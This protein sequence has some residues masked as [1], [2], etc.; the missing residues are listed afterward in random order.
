MLAAK[1]REL[2]DLKKKLDY[3]RSFYADTPEDVEEVS[4]S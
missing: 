4:D 3:A 1:R 2:E